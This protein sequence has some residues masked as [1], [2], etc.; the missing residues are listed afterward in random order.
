M[1]SVFSGTV[2]GF[3]T[4]NGAAQ[5][6]QIR[7]DVD[8][9]NVYNTTVAA[10]NQTTAKG[11]QYY[12]QRGFPA[13]AMIAYFK[14]N[15]ANAANLTQYLT[16]GGFTLINNTIN[17][18]GASIAISA[19]SNATPPVV[20]TANTGSLSNGNI[21]RLF[22]VTGAQQLGGLDFTIGNV[23]TNTSFTL[24]Y[25]P[26]IVAGTTGTYRA[27]PF[28][29]YFYPPTRVISNISQAV[30]P[31]ITLLVTHAF[32]VGQRV[33]LIVPT[34]T[35]TAYGMTQ[36]NN[37]ETTIVAINQ[38]DSNGVTN[39]ITVNVDTSAMTAFAWPLTADPVHTPAQ[40]VPVGENTAQAI[41]SGTNILGDSEINLGYI[42]I[43]LAGGASSPGGA[44]NDVLYWVAGKSFS[45]GA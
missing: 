38:A 16:T 13:G 8:W 25:A 34:V 33:R 45:G 3:F 32:T 15:A 44:N 12:W 24:A 22:N 14:S 7:E 43:S 30:Q 29:Y 36:L 11:V 27:I 35:A 4:S 21:V 6:L 26:T 42:G 2:Q 17:I 9:I 41:T 1:S 28:D 40:V 37:V 10:A 5:I 23:V 39:T 31:I 20:S 19:V 18:P